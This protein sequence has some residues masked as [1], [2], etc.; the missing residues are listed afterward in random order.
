LRRGLCV[1]REKTPGVAGAP[2]E[3]D[4][5]FK[6]ECRL[7]LDEVDFETFQGAVKRFGYRTNLN[8]EHIKSISKEI[9]L[10]PAELGE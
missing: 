10:N 8:V 3:E 4:Y 5:V 7:K 2:P 6:S 9:K 1:Q